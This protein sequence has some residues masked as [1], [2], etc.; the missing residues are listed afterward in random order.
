MLLLYKSMVRPHLEYAVQAWSPNKI[1]AIK[2]LEEVQRRLTKCI[3]ELN[4]LPWHMR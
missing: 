3:P 4:K 2:L 1:S